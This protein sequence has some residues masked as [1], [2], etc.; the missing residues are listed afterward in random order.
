ME[1]FCQFF[2][3]D[4]PDYSVIIEDDTIVAYVYLMLGE[5]IIGD[6]WLYNRITPPENYKWSR[7]NL[8]L[9]LPPRLIKGKQILIDPPA[10]T[11]FK[12]KWEGNEQSNLL[13]V[14]VTLHERKVI[15]KPGELPGWSSE[16]LQDSRFAKALK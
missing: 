16:V 11:D 13:E 5:E 9:L 3:E 15:L 10:T 6:V 14:Q 4:N 12:L 8:P 1:L 7:E 2:W